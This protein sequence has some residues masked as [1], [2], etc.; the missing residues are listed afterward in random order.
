MQCDTKEASTAVCPCPEPSVSSL[1]AHARVVLTE[2][3]CNHT[4]L[5]RPTLLLHNT[6][7]IR[8]AT[9]IVAR[10]IPAQQLQPALPVSDG[11]MDAAV[12]QGTAASAC[13]CSIPR[14]CPT[15]THTSCCSPLAPPRGRRTQ[16]LCAQGQTQQQTRLRIQAGQ[17][18][19]LECSCLSQAL[20]C[21]RWSCNT[22]GLSQGPNNLT[23]AKTN[24]QEGQPMQLLHM[25]TA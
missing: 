9:Q 20:E 23:K 15:I 14:P 22:S 13:C 3:M 12:A 25:A 18:A 2:Q 16:Q 6:P 10:K 5:L 11:P 21:L 8:H 24:N 1:S 19:L 17:P 7:K 4:L